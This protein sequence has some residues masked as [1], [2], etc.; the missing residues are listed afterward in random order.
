MVDSLL[1]SCQ[2]FQI[3]STLRKHEQDAEKE[4]ENIEFLGTNQW[5]EKKDTISHRNHNGTFICV[6]I[7]NVDKLNM[8]KWAMQ[9]LKL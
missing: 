5:P 1:T 3:G 6:N 2:N 4:I 7:E 8:A 9:N